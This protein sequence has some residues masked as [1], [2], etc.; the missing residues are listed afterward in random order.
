VK[1]LIDTK[2]IAERLSVTRKYVTDKL[3]KR[4][5][6]PRPVVDVSSHLRRW[7]ASDVDRYCLRSDARRNV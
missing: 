1:D 2:G 5:D 6:F 7:R 3:T 4:P